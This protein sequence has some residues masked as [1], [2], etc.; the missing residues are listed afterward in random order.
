MP[1]SDQTIWCRS[2]NAPIDAEPKP[3][4]NTG[5]GT[6]VG[7]RS[8]SNGAAIDPNPIPSDRCTIA[9]TTI[10]KIARRRISGDE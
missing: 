6:K 5:N 1:T 3:S 10:M 2:E 9:A 7:S 8:A 4:I